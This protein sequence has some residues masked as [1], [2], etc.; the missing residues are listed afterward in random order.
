MTNGY[1]NMTAQDIKKKEKQCSRN[2]EPLLVSHHAVYDVPWNDKNR[3]SETQVHHIYSL[4]PLPDPL[5]ERFSFAY[6]FTNNDFFPL[7]HKQITR[8]NY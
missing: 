1:S 2:V 7:L 3:E 8:Y 5:T 4:L 6:F